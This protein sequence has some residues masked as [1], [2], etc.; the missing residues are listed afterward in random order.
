MSF[1]DDKHQNIPLHGLRDEFV[2]GLSA[3]MRKIDRGGRIGRPDAQALAWL[4]GGEPLSR[5]QDRERAQQAPYIDFRLV[6][7]QMPVLLDWR[8]VYFLNAQLSAKCC[9]LRDQIAPL[10]QNAIT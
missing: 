10:D 5:L 9:I 1:P 3:I 4:H 7:H 6:V 8:M 2:A